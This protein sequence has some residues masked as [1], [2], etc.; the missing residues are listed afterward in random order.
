MICVLGNVTPNGLREEP[1][2]PVSKFV[3]VIGSYVTPLGTVTLS[4]VKVELFTIAFTAPNQTTLFATMVLK[5]VPVIV[6]DVP[7]GPEVGEKDVIVGI[8]LPIGVALAAKL[9][10][11]SIRELSKADTRK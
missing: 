1:V 8:I 10:P 4:D 9:F 2:N 7:I 11:L 3:I 5:F 6:T